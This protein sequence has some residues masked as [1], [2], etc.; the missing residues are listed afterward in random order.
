MMK[1]PLAI[2]LPLALRGLSPLFVLGSL[3]HILKDIAES[4]IQKSSPKHRSQVCACV[5]LYVCVYG[6]GL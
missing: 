6:S 2:L 1:V 3:Q 5:Y 4:G